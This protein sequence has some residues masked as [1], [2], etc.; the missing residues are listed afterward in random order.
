VDG[1]TGLHPGLVTKSLHPLQALALNGQGTNVV[2][3]RLHGRCQVAKLTWEILVN[4]EY[5]HLKGK[6]LSGWF[7]EFKIL[8]FII[9][10]V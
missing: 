2:S 4:E 5:P 1:L 8:F 10:S 3:S 7:E 6:K 9:N